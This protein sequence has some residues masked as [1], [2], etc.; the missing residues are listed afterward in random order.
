MHGVEPGTLHDCLRRIDRNRFATSSFVDRSDSSVAHAGGPRIAPISVNSL[1]RKI[2]EQ[3]PPPSTQNFEQCGWQSLTEPAA[4][5]P[6]LAAA[7]AA[8]VEPISNA[9]S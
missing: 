9:G 1:A 4:N 6:P 2:Y 5:M 3:L 7:A 8:K